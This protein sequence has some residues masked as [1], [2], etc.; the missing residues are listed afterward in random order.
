MK[1]RIK[2]T[3]C[4]IRHRWSRWAYEKYE[5]DEGPPEV[6]HDVQFRMCTRCGHS[7]IREPVNA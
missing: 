2:G 7:E 3:T 5:M 4:R 1:L 6:I